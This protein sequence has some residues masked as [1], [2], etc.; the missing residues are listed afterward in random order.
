MLRGLLQEKGPM[1]INFA[2]YSHENLQ[3]IQPMKGPKKTCRREDLYD[4]V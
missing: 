4:F 2:K 3:R 1:G